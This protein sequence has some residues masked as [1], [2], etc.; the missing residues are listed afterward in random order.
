LIME[1]YTNRLLS[2]FHVSPNIP[3]HS[4]FPVVTDYKHPCAD[5]QQ[6]FLYVF[7]QTPVKSKSGM[8]S[9]VAEHSS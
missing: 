2:V 6:I 9:S 5:C 8:N 1:S 7:C 3:F 4:L